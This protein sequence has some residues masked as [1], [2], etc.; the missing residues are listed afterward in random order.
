MA[1]RSPI[2]YDTPLSLSITTFIRSH[3]ALKGKTPAETAGI[4]V[5]GENKRMELLRRSLRN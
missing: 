5:D 3:P 4:G 2:E 1:G